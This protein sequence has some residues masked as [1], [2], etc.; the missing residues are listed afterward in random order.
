[1]D[2]RF[3]LTPTNSLA[4][5]S[6][7]VLK[8]DGVEDPLINVDTLSNFDLEESYFS[9]AI[10]FISECNTEYTKIK[11]KLYTAIAESTTETAVLE[12]YSEY[13]VK[14]KAIIDKFL[15]FMKIMM[16]KHI[17]ATVNIIQSDKSLL[18]HKKDFD[19]FKGTFE[20]NGFNYTFSETVPNANAAYEYMNSLFDKLNANARNELTMGAVENAL[21]SI[22]L[23]DDFAKFRGLVIGKHYPIRGVDFSSELFKVYRNG[24][25][26]TETIIATESYVKMVRDRYF[27]I[28]AT[29]ETAKRSYI[30]IRD[31]YAKLE[32]ELEHI[33]DANGNLNIRAFLGVLPENKNIKSVVN[34]AITGISMSAEF[35]SKLDVYIKAKIAQIEGY[36]NIHILAYAAKLDALK[37]CT[38]Q[39]RNT[40][41]QALLTMTT[42]GGK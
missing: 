4:S 35:M 17:S 23:E 40:L 16:D 25:S 38:I 10:S 26:D 27:D 19:K 41:Y 8:I 18:S 15:K 6:F 11:Q 36:S 9:Q 32:K 37:E 39:D 5:A 13:F 31:A 21:R 3:G 28:G 29:K 2:N 24:K 30:Q 42:N 1:M 12:G 22:S 33:I 14:A 7:D 34:T 20:I